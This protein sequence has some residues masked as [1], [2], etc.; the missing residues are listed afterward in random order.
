MRMRHT[1]REIDG[2]FAIFGRAL[3]WIGRN[4]RDPAGIFTVGNFDT[5][6]DIGSNMVSG[7]TLRHLNLDRIVTRF[8]RFQQL[9]VH[10]NRHANMMPVF[11]LLGELSVRPHR[12]VIR[13]PSDYA[14]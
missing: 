9:G 1:F 10:R 4:I 5:H 6:N 11:H 2:V 14:V 3:I 7:R 12:L 8:R 13:K